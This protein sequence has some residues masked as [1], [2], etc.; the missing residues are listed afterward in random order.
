MNGDYKYFYFSMLGGII[1]MAG[2]FYSSEFGFLSL[3]FIASGFLTLFPLLI[4]YLYLKECL[5]FK[6]GVKK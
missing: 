1:F 5:Y 4:F 3:K 2:V 6:Q